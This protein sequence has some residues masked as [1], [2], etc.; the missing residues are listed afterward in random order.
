M[1][2]VIR[3]QTRRGAWTDLE[4]G[5]RDPLTGLPDRSTVERCLRQL[6]A[7]PGGVSVAV[8]RIDHAQRL[9]AE[10]GE[11][12]MERL[13]AHVARTLVECLRDD[14]LVGRLSGR[15]FIL[16]LRV[17]DA[18]AGR[19]ACERLRLRVAS[20]PIE[21]VNP[22]ISVGLTDVQDTPKPRWGTPN[23]R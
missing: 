23:R 11:A 19:A 20:R 1:Q 21:G 3:R 4:S 16:L 8:V 5:P 17:P 18:R 9:E 7:R 10:R 14:D 12:F 6:A 15:Q 2:E 13:T 22:S